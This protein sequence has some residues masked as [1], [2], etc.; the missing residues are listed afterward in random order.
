LYTARDRDCCFSHAGKA[1][2]YCG[3]RSDGPSGGF[4]SGV[5]HALAAAATD[6]D[7]YTNADADAGA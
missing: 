6:A 5:S 7:S 4:S 1:V 2:T 3:C